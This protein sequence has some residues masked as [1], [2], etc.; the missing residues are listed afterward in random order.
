MVCPNCKYEVEIDDRFCQSCGYSLKL[1]PIIKLL[2][3]LVVLSYLIMSQYFPNILEDVDPL[4]NEI[5]NITLDTAFFL[6]AIFYIS[7]IVL[8]MYASIYE[9]RGFTQ[10]FY[11]QSTIVY[12]VIEV[13][14]WYFF[15]HNLFFSQLIFN[16][17][18]IEGIR[19]DYLY[20]FIIYVPIQTVLLRRFLIT[21]RSIEFQ[22]T[23]VSQAA[24]KTILFTSCMLGISLRLFGE[25]A[26]SI[27]KKLDIY[28][29]WF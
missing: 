14:R 22:R 29:F 17:E 20:A 18:I 24:Y 3:L 5:G 4:S 23:I 1:S 9:I 2:I 6:I 28:I 8:S 25:I 21:S 27:V 26:K 13:I 19:F 16:P 11:V 10:G 12:S 15:E 7:K